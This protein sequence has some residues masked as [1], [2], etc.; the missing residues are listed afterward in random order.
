MRAFFMTELLSLL[1]SPLQPES[2]NTD[3]DTFLKELENKLLIILRTN[4]DTLSN[5]LY[6]IDIEESKARRAFQL[7]E[8]Y[9]ISNEI[10]ILI[11]ERL[12][13]K[14]EMRKRYS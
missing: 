9:L 8:D 13:K 11:L 5:L 1:P 2:S 6:Q 4:P 3:K 12:E 10:A 14:L 7:K